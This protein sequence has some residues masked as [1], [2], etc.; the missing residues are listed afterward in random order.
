LTAVNI[1]ILPEVYMYVSLT[2]KLILVDF[3]YPV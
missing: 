2:A 3:D 1:H